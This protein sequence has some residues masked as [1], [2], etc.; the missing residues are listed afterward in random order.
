LNASLK[1]SQKTKIVTANSDSDDDFVV[2]EQNIQESDLQNK[3]YK[4]EDDDDNLNGTKNKD[5]EKD[6]EEH[7]G[8]VK[9]ILE[10]KEQMEH[11]SDMNRSRADFVSLFN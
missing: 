4:N 2:K 6:G 5:L 3:F 9:K 11:G 8:L 7:G 10:S 1:S